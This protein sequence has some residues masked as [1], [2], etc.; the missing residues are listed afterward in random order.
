MAKDSYISGNRLEYIVLLANGMLPLADLNVV[1][2][3]LKEGRRGI[4]VEDFGRVNSSM[5]DIKAH[6][7]TKLIIR[8]LIAQSKQ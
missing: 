1:P 3:K 5:K 7:V 6:L 4:P 8:R 2:V